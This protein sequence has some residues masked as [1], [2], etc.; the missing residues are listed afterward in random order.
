MRPVFAQ[1][2]HALFVCSVNT[3]AL[4]ATKDGVPSPE[5]LQ[6]RFYNLLLAFT[7]SNWKVQ[8]L[9]L[10]SVAPK[11][12]SQSLSPH[13]SAHGVPALGILFP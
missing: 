3:R 4:P 8:H 10:S 5:Y 9:A 12:H 13:Q 6:V 1:S 2:E 7:E 11:I